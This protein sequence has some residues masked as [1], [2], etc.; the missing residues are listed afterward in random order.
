M[1]NIL[2]QG[3]VLNFQGKTYP[4]AIGRSGIKPEEDKREGD[5]ATPSGCFPLREVLYRADRVEEPKTKLPSGEIELEDGW[6]DDPEDENYNQLITLPY[7]ASHEELWREDHLY[8]IIVPI[9]YND[10]P[11]IPGAGS[12][13]F[14][15]IA[16]EDYAPTA[17]CVALKKEDL[18]EV[19]EGCTPETQICIE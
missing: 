4:C 9:G 10:D 17:G 12:A 2:V 13:I 11:A 14:M 16:R 15:H 5:G 3:K 6:C 7:E 8:D 18:L 19:L 1:E